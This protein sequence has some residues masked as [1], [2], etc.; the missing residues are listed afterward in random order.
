MQDIIFESESPDGRRLAIFE[1][2]G[3]SAWLYL[4][5]ASNH[6]VEKDAFVYSPQPPRA[7]LNRDGMRDGE[8]P[9]LT[10]EY[11]SEH[12]VVDIEDEMALSI[13]WS[14]SGKSLAVFHNETVLA[15]I[16]EDEPQGYSK[17]LS[18]RG[19]F[20]KPWSQSKFEQF[21]NEQI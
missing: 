16:Y 14:D 3:S 7:E 20:G 17:A 18:K 9:I 13:V 10:Q 2:N 12:A 1:D 8:P 21:F 5:S 15:A 4:A 11:A 6:D 19:G